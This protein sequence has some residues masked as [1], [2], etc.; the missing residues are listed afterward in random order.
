[1]KFSKRNAAI[2]ASLILFLSACG[3][4]DYLQLAVGAAEIALP[5]IGPSAGV[6]PATIASVSTYLA[7]TSQGITCATD[8][9]SGPG[10]DAQKAV[11]SIACFAGIAAPVV[12]AKYQAL[13]N[14]VQQVALYIAKY[15]ATLPVPSTSTVGKTTTP[16][17]TRLSILGQV[18]A[19]ARSVHDRAQAV[20]NSTPH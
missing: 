5:L 16:N 19:R 20:Y 13:V 15:L 14:A 1:M 10:T 7:A 6:D 17:A 9:E 4:L 18:R 11:Q 2:A 8:V 12:P 3:A